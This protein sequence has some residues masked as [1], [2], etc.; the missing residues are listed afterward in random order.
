[1]V[2]VSDWSLTITNE[3]ENSYRFVQWLNHNPNL[4]TFYQDSLGFVRGSIFV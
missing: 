2:C 3:T 1:M 4:F